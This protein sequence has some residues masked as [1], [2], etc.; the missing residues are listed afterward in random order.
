MKI[1]IAEHYG[2]CFGVRD[3]IAHA[4]E[5]AEAG[6]LTILGEL[7]HNP[8]V[9][10]RFERLGVHTGALD[11][12]ASSP[13]DRVLITAHGA[14]DRARKAWE[15]AGH[16]VS[17]GTCPLVHHAHQALAR[18][19]EAGCFPVVIGRPGHVEV[20]GLAGDF[21]DA[22]V[23][24]S[25]SDIHLLPVRTLYGVIAQTTQPIDEARGLVEAI[26][27]ARPGS[28]VRFVDT[29]CKPTKDRQAALGKLLSDCDT[30][31]VVGGRNSNNTLELAATAAS[32]G[33]RVHHIERSE[34][35]LPQ[36]FADC[37]DVGV[38]GGTST[39]K[40]TV[41]EVAARLREMSDTENSACAG[42]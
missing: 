7:V 13:T 11:D 23:I 27:L 5:L 9:K 33:L 14:S 40:E 41:A 16:A 31:V 8:I 12:T 22:C 29:V 35:L 15:L 4:S 25:E 42:R 37:L 24:D 38:T 39:L 10:E 2:V 6:A 26:R 3:A 36:W 32:A 28:E 34:E 18:L 30:I 19:V 1:H 17:D 20:R 21:P